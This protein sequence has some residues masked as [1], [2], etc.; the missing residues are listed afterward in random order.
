M[1]PV[2]GVGVLGMGPMELVIILAIVLILFGAGRLPQ[3]FEQFGKGIKAFRDGQKDDA[4]DVTRAPPRAELT[5]DPMSDAR[6][7]ERDKQ[8]T[9]TD[10]KV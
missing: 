7:I 6:E 1:A 5:D 8:R 3:V 2:L 9:G 10:H 4:I